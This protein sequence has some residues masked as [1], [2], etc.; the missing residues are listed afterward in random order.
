MARGKKA[1]KLQA[2]EAQHHPE[3]M[4]AFGYPGVKISLNVGDAPTVSPVVDRATHRQ[5]PTAKEPLPKNWQYTCVA[6]YQPAS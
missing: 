1:F 6:I 3:K 2:A 5:A 4:A